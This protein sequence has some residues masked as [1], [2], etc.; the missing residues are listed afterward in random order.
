LDFAPDNLTNNEFGWKTTWKD[1]RIQWNGAI[2]QEDWNNAQIN[3]FASRVITYG[4]IVNG[5]NYRVRGV[6][7]SGVARITTGLT[8]SAGAAWNHSELVKPA[9]FLWADGTPIDFGVLRTSN[10]QKFPNPG[11]AQGS[12]LAGHWLGMGGPVALS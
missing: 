6:E 4:V 9:T 1:R 7:T 2:Y 8:L 3:V 12:S 5:G 11:G 10:G